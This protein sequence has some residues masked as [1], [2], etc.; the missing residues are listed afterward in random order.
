M[1]KCGEQEAMDGRIDDGR[2]GGAWRVS[3]ASLDPH[4]HWPAGRFKKQTGDVMKIG[5]SRHN[6]M[7]FLVTLAAVCALAPELRADWG[8]LR[9]NNRPAVRRRSDF[10]A[11]R[12]YAF[13]WARFY[14]GMAVG[15][16]PVGYVQTSV[17]LTGYY[18]YDGVYFRPTT[19]GAYTVV[20]PPVGA[21]VP[22][23]PDGAEAIVIGE[24]TY[25][26]GGGAFYL[27]QPTGFVVVEAPVGVTVPGLPLGAAPAVINGVTYYLAGSTYFL[28]VMQGG[29]TVY[30][31][32]HP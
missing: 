28:P 27:P 2:V 21:I 22:Q 17:G 7:K 12:R 32:A 20:A 18:Y 29:V 1:H 5:L 9:A 13:Y 31:T 16:L 14:P 6:R 10:E 26:Y 4:Q 23:L 3:R 30:V 25:Y 19:E 15:V 24:D 11:E 8:S